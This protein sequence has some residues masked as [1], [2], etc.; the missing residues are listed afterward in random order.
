TVRYFL[1][2]LAKGVGVD[3][4]QTTARLADLVAEKL[5]RTP[6]PIFVDQA[7]FLNEKALGVI[8]YIW[9]IARIPVVLAG[10]QLL[11]E[12]FHSSRMAQDERAQLARRVALH[13]PLAELRPEQARAI[14]ERAIPGLTKEEVAQIVKLTGG[15]HGSLESMITRILDLRKRNDT[16]LKE[17]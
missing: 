3:E 16:A 2:K 17:G 6:K 15:N 12:T 10:T 4:S 11:Y 13:Y 14:V 7:N 8:C 9:D 5:R 1:Q